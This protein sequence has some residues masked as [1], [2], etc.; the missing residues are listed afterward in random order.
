ARTYMD[1]PDVDGMI[2]IRSREPLYTGDIVEA[3]VIS[4]SGYDLIGVYES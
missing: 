1:A 2:F 3:K 4:S